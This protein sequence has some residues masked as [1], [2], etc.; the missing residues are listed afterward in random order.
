MTRGKVFDEGENEMAKSTR[1][2]ELRSIAERAAAGLVAHGEALLQAVLV[3]GGKPLVAKVERA[4]ADGG[5]L[6]IELELRPG[7]RQINIVVRPTDED[8]QV[9][10]VATLDGTLPTRGR[11]DDEGEMRLVN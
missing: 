5:G 7:G 4:L 11:Y 1:T 10:I 9:L 2:K 3:A 8:E 6:R